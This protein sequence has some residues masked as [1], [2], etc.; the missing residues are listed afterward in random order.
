MVA[1]GSFV[2]LCH[3]SSDCPGLAHTE[4]HGPTFSHS[5]IL[6]TQHSCPICS[7]S[8]GSVCTLRRRK[9]APPGSL[10]L[11]A[12]DES[13]ITLHKSEAAFG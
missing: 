3:A 1:R 7:H 12:Q 5:R 10:A 13:T 9:T 2:E 11:L 4:P 6:L 8:A